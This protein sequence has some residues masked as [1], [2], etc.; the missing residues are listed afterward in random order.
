MSRV[1]KSESQA[2]VNTVLFPNRDRL[3]CLLFGL[4]FA[5]ICVLAA[6]AR[7]NSDLAL[8]WPANAF[9]IGMLIRFPTLARPLGWISCFVGFEIAVWIIGRS[10]IESV[11]LTAYNFGVV[12]TGYLLLSSYDRIDQLLS[13]Q[14]SVLYLLSAI[15]A[16]C[17]FAGIFGVI[18]VGPLF[19]EPIK[20]SSF[21]YWFSVELW[22]QLAF[23]PMV[24]S[25]PR[26]FRWEWRRPQLNYQKLAPVVVLVASAVLGIFFGR[27]GTLTFPVPALLWCAI[28][29]RTFLTSLLTCAFCMWAVLATTLGYIGTSLFDRELVVSISMGAAL[30]SLGPLIVSTTTA[31]RNEVLDQLRYLAAEREIVSNE[32]GHRIKNLFALVNGLISLSV[33]DNPE[34]ISLADTLKSRLAALH[35][36]HGLI[37][38]GNTSPSDGDGLTSLRELIASL[39]MPY[40]VNRR[41]EMA[42]DDAL[43]KG[44][45]V[46]SLALVFHE[47]ATNS[48]K[49]GALSSPVGTLSVHISRNADDVHIRWTENGFTPSIQP[50]V[51]SGGFG[52]KLLDLTLKSQL[53]GNYARNMTSTG[54]DIDIVLPITLFSVPAD[55]A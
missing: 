15:V 19:G 27:M 13:R 40:E 25:F 50:D 8:I 18:F 49:Y 44:G 32:L 1:S 12:A 4:A 2:G 35:R 28:S 47:L 16:A 33:R 53:R 21:P 30:I 14:I 31:T 29:Y 5:T 52:S 54:M 10:L 34:M 22:N 37:R 11:G 36:A 51:G 42:G 55:P 39:L 6:M 3:F 48:T 46:T 45:I 26:D 24:L 17:L 7:N 23:L 9:M 38:T 43:V 41:F 20:A